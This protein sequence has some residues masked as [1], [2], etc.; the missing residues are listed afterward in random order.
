MRLGP[1]SSRPVPR[2]RREACLT[3]E[4]PG[5]ARSCSTRPQKVQPETAS[6]RSRVPTRTAHSSWA[7]A[8]CLP[9]HGPRLR[10]IVVITAG[11]RFVRGPDR[12]PQARR[13]QARRLRIS[14]GQPCRR[15]YVTTSSS[16]GGRGRS[17]GG[18]PRVPPSG[19]VTGT[20]P[21]P[22]ALPVEWAD[23]GGTFVTAAP[24]DWTAASSSGVQGGQAP[25]KIGLDLRLFRFANL[26]CR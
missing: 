3:L 6:G 25:T 26:R 21:V 14:P 11:R 16:P 23:S 2:R 19:Q 22:S 13:P 20:V 1:E 4:K 15:F 5:S 17:T 7:S 8:A 18:G 24:A 9:V 12:G 10:V